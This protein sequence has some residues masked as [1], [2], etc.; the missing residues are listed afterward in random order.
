MYSPA[1]DRP[2]T[3]ATL[4]SIPDSQVELI[5]DEFDHW[6]LPDTL[7]QPCGGTWCAADVVVRRR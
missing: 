4:N 3:T 5:I 7:V 6:T 1:I 2:A